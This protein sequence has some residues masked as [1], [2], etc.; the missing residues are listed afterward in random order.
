M[1]MPNNSFEYAIFT[2]LSTWHD[3]FTFL[4]ALPSCIGFPMTLSSSLLFF[5]TS[6]AKNNEMEYFVVY[7]LDFMKKI[8]IFQKI[9]KIKIAM[10]KHI[11]NAN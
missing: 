7:S 5:F 8:A 10:S 1:I 11:L 2:S 6:V 4:M 3:L 9:L